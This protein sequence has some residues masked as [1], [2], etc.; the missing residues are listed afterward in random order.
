MLG[1]I[2][3]SKPNVRSVMAASWSDTYPTGTLETNGVS[4]S[5][6]ARP[7]DRFD[8]SPLP[9]GEYVFVV[10]DNYSRYFEVDI[11]KSVTSANITDCLARIFCTDGLP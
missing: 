1:L 6:L 11:L 3:R 4:K 8:G 2:D 5:A 7:S 10:V 9:S